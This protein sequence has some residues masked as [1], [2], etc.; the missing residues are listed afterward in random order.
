MS[1]QAAVSLHPQIHTGK[2]GGGGYLGGG[3]AHG[4]AREFGVHFH[5]YCFTG[6]NSDYQFVTGNIFEDSACD[7]FELD[8]D[9]CLLFVQGYCQI[10]PLDRDVWGYL[11]RL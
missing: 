11:F 8:S 7:I 2:W 6:L 9:F 5:I 10:C 1:N 4:K 3:G